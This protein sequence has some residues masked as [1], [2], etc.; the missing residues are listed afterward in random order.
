MAW[1]TLDTQPAMLAAGLNISPD[2]LTAS[3]SNT[4]GDAKTNHVLAT[5]FEGKRSGKW[6]IE[7]RCIFQSAN[8][9][10]AGYDRIGV[11]YFASRG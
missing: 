8:D 5:A 2:G 11:S 9:G 4:M 3:S 1:D 6:C 7:I 10:F